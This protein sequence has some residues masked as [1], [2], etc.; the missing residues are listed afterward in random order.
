MEWYQENIPNCTRSFIRESIES[1]EAIALG[2]SIVE[3]RPASK[4]ADDFKAVFEEIAKCINV[5][6]DV[7][8]ESAHQIYSSPT[9]THFEVNAHGPLSKKVKRAPVIA[10]D[11][12]ATT[13]KSTKRSLS[14]NSDSLIKE[15]EIKKDG[16]DP[17]IL[18][19]RAQ[20]SIGTPPWSEVVV[21]EKDQNRVP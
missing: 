5:R 10:K 3:Y 2:Q 9:H 13:T 8:N 17:E 4:C 15:T 21:R 18:P 14:K 19:E 11:D 6:E 1:E 20:L 12:F 16:S 7:V